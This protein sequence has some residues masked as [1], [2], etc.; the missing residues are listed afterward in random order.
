MEEAKKRKLKLTHQ[1]IL[2]IV[3]V[4]LVLVFGIM[5]PVFFYPD[6]LLDVTAIIG[7]IGIMALAMTFI[8]TT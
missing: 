5:E 6:V 7:E 8:I 4:G 1:L 3:L 2:I